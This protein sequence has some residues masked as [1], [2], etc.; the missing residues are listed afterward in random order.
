[1]APGRFV[2]DVARGLRRLVAGGA[3]SGIS[4]L[5]P[6]AGEIRR[7]TV[8]E[9]VA[10]YRGTSR[11]ARYETVHPEARASN[12]LPCNVG[13]IDELPDDRGWWGFS[14]R[15]VPSRK[16]G[17]TFIATVPDCRVVWYRDPQ[18]HEFYPA[19]LPSDGRALDLR[20]IRFRPLHA[21]ALRRSGAPLRVERATW[22]LERV[23]HN[24]SHWLTAH[25][26]KL[27]LLRERNALDDVWLSRELTPPIEASLRML[28]LPPEQFQAFD[29]ARPLHVGELT[30][31]GT[32]RFRPELLVKVPDAFGVFD[33]PPP[34]RRVF[35]SRGNAPRRRLLNEAE[36]WPLLEAAGFERVQMEALA[37]PDQV[38]LMRETAILWAPHGAGLTN[39]L[40][41]PPRA[42][43]V[44]MADLAFP[45]P[46][47][48]ALAS[49]MRHS[50][51]IVPATSTGDVH[52]LEKDLVADL[53][54]VRRVIADVLARCDEGATR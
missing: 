26:P 6:R 42:H 12:P 20:E 38:A 2:A 8:Q 40:F 32:D 5:W 51:W 18:Q 44:E 27:L 46:N 16:S 36:V 21:E 53:S 4:R 7:Q 54:L 24:H 50:Y 33:A 28:G 22:V 30:L 15:D 19:I 41:C 31:V 43:V 10:R 37:F 49:A 25:V 52:P 11:A 35:I 29:P 34:R 1:M 39:M 9:Y 17:E 14:F 3:A 48:Y 23:Y 47:F 13:S 45:N